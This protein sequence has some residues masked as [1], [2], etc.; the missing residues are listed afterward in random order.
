MAGIVQ[1]YTPLH[2]PHCRH[3]AMSNDRSDDSIEAIAMMVL[4][5]MLPGAGD[6]EMNDIESVRVRASDKKQNL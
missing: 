4:D 3:I 5:G 2:T 6:N 1:R